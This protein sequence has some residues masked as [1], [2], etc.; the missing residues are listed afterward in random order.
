AGAQAASHL[1]RVLGRLP[2]GLEQHALLRVHE[3]RLARGDAEEAGV[4]PVDPVDEAP[5]ARDRLTRVSWHG[6]VVCVD[7]PAIG[8]DLAHRVDPVAEKLPERSRVVGASGKPAAD[9]DD[10]DGLSTQGSPLS[11]FLRAA[12]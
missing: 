10:G 4:E 3:R 9:T 6:I 2:A 12:R 11:P 1:A 5:E 8:W 7:R